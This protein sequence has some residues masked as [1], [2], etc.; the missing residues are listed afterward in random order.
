[1]AIFKINNQKLEPIEERRI[2]LERDIQKLTEENLETV[3][4]LKFVSGSLNQEFC[5]HVSEQDFYID[6]VAFDESTDSVVLIEYKKDRSFSVIDQGFAYLSAMLNNKAD[7]VLELNE[8]LKKNFSKK[9]IDWEQ[10]RIIFISNEFNNYQKNAINFKDLPMFLYEVKVYDN[11]IDYNPIKPFKTSESINKFVKDKNIQ[12]VSREVKV[13]SVDDLVKP[14]WA[15]TREMLNQFSEELLKL[16]LVTRIKYTKFY[17]AYMTNHGKNFVEIVPQQQGLKTYFR[18][19]A[20]SVKSTMK[21]HDCSKVG[22]F[23]NGVSYVDIS[24]QNQISESIR[25]SIKS[26]EFLQKE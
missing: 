1:M 17:V 25:L 10:S 2:D 12:R 14:Q 7:F 18:F 22:R 19:P 8:R 16:N 4:G 9:D 13:Y 5:V 20:D 21:I 26:Y 6:T 11:L 15:E 24:D 23:A 3:F